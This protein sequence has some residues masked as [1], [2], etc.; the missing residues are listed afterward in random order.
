MRN[1]AYHSSDPNAAVARAA[2][3]RVW[4]AAAI[5]LGAGATALVAPAAALLVV[6]L[7][8]ARALARGESL[9]FQPAALAGPALAA[10]VVGALVGFSAGIGVLFVWR[11]FSD[12]R[13]SAAEAARLARAAGRHEEAA[14]LAL[15]HVWLTPLFGLTLVAY[16][17]PHMVAGLPLDLPHLPLWAPLVAGGAALG[18]LF[19]WGLRRAAD[20]RL[21]ELAGAPAAH[22]LAHHAVFVLAFG[23]GLDVS[24]GIVA[25]AAWRLWQVSDARRAARDA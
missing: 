16:T 18:A 13:W 21:D 10:L 2:P 1:G 22:L 7:L 3:S 8:G 14:P 5:A 15:V 23:A 19:D 20:W 25:L 17:A 9:Q 12:A 24:A 6:A 4:S 11:L